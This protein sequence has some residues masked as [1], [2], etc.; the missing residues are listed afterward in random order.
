MT[1]AQEAGINA[2]FLFSYRASL[3]KSHHPTESQVYPTNMVF[4]L[5]VYD[6]LDT[7]SQ[8]GSSVRWDGIEKHAFS[9]LKRV[10]GIWDLTQLFQT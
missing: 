4:A 9:A 1:S 6:T 7:F 8:N 5:S 3:Q 2:V 10:S